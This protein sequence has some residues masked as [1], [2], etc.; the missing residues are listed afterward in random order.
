[1]IDTFKDASLSAKGIDPDF[2][3]TFDPTELSI[4]P[5]FSSDSFSYEYLSG[6]GVVNKAGKITFDYTEAMFFQQQRVTNTRNLERGTYYFQ[7]Q[8]TLF[9]NQ[10]VW[11]DTS[12][13]PDEVVSIKT[14]N[15][16]I[17]I[18]TSA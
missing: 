13:A 9:P 18:Q 3:I 8:M 10:D 15:S 7:G 2:R 14:H 6:N 1:M 4:R 5:L 12:C 11:V 16:L 17:S